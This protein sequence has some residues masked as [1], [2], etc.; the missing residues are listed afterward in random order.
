MNNIF[1]VYI[2]LDPRKNG[3][4][5]YGDYE[6]E[7]EPFYVGKGYGGRDKVHIKESYR[8]DD[9]KRGIS[10]FKCNKIRKIYKEIEKEP[11]ILKIKENI[12]DEFALELEKKAIKI[13]GR[14]NLG[15]GPLT[16]LTDGGEGFSGYIATEETKRKN[17]EIKKGEKNPMWGKKRDDLKNNPIFKSKEWR[18]KMSKLTSGKNNPMYGKKREHTKETRKKQSEANKGEKN[19]NWGKTASE[20]TRKRMSESLKGKNKGKNNPMFGK[21]HSEKS[22]RKMSEK[23]KGKNNPMFGKHHSERTKRKMSEKTKGK[24]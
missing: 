17:S 12:T 3:G 23:K 8:R 14:I 20:E 15:N 2:Y 24:P 21:S 11:I 4:F 1:Y 6:F 18:E 7:Y 22:K 19:P 9:I 5:K 13:I 10:S 16:N